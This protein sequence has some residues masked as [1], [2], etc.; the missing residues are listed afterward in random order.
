[1][2][3][4]S[5]LA[6]VAVLA[7]AGLGLAGCGG[8]DSGSGS[9]ATTTTTTQS[10]AEKQAAYAN[11][12]CGALATWKDSLAS[13]ATTLKGGSL[14][15]EKLQ[16]AATTV[17]DANAKL[18]DEVKSLGAPKI[19]GPQAK[20]SLNS[21]SDELESSADEIDKAAKGVSNAPEAMAAVGTASA[22]LLKMSTDISTTL[23]E[24]QS[25]N[26]AGGWKQAFAN[27][28]SCQSLSKS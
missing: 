22:A 24:L 10:A 8:S 4:K 2:A 9:G 14:T 5:L 1:V 3:R 28:A 20:A 6:L 17:S 16:E 13:V 25:L 7:L 18:A 23:T 21:L 19:A 12:L 26:V 27:S 11:T 15:K